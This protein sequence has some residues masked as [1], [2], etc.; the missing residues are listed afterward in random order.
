MSDMPCAQKYEMLF[1]LDLLV[2]IEES[3]LY[4]DSPIGATNKEVEIVKVARH[5]ECRNFPPQIWKLYFDGSK[6]QEG[7]GVG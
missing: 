1:Q 2:G 6:S 4:Q 7:S 3:I 5:E